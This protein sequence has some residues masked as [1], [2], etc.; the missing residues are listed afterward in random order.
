[1]S[2]F[3]WSYPPGCS[4]YDEPVQSRCS[5]GAFV[6]AVASFHKEVWEEEIDMSAR[7][8]VFHPGPNLQVLS[9]TRRPGPWDESGE[10]TLWKWRIR[11]KSLYPYTTYKRCGAE[12]LLGE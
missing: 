7:K 1:M 6:S 8:P 5:C 10:K 3:G 12:V 2:I 4:D 9:L 11:V